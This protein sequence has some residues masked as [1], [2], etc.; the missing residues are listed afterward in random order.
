MKRFKILF[1]K[2]FIYF[3]VHQILLLG[4]KTY[5]YLSRKT[6]LLYKKARIQSEDIPSS[7]SHNE[8][9]INHSSRHHE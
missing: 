5:D 9:E 8:L 7:F 6:G 3:F 1:F 4:F 2:N